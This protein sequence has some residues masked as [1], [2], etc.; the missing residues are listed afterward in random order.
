MREGGNKERQA[1]LMS[2]VLRHLGAGSV[3]PKVNCEVVAGEVIN[4][5]MGIDYK[6]CIEVKL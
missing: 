5:L 1:R 2:K 6:S 3:R 4:L